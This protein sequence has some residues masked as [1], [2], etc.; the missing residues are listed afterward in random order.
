MNDRILALDAGAN[1]V[2]I[3]SRHC[4]RLAPVIY[5]FRRIGDDIVIACIKEQE[6]EQDLLQFW[7]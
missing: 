3:F 7:G 1:T 4:S 6:S 2:S 5:G